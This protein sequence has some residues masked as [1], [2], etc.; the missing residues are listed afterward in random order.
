MDFTMQSLNALFNR[1]KGIGFFERLFG[2]NKVQGLLTDASAELGALQQSNMENGKQLSLKEISLSEL[3]KDVDLLKISE[4]TLQLKV[5]Q[6]AAE[7][8][9]LREAG[10]KVKQMHA[11]EL[12]S[13]RQKELTIL[14]LTNDRNNIQEKYNQIAKD[15]NEVKV[16]LASL[17][18]NEEF[19][20]TEHNDAVSSL[21]A[22][23]QKI[24]NDREKELEK[25]QE[26]E[27]DRISNLKTTWSEHQTLA[28][29]FIKA[30]CGKHTIEFVD[31]VPFKGTPDNT[32]KVA[33]EYIVFDAKSPG[34]EDLNNFPAYIKREAE[35]A[36]KYASQD[37]VRREIFFV[38]PSNTLE[39]V[40]QFVYP[41]AEYT[42]Y[43]ISLDALEPVILSLKRIE[44]YEFAEELTPEERSN[45]C[46]VLGKF[47]H[48]T[49]RRIQVD[50]FFAK[51]AIELAY[52]A[53]ATLPDFI[54]EEVINFERADKL[55]PP[56]E[57]RTKQIPVKDLEKDINKL[58]QEAKG[59]GINIDSEPLADKI[60]E[61]PLYDN[62]VNE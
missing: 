55:N 9:T 50:S 43:L 62:E 11:A 58:E 19:R 36:K 33:G 10:G 29:Q 1:L 30:I 40:K 16:K 46:R 41:M 4:S 12:A 13:N 2:W 60:N 26:K 27:Q 56:L 17:E 39:V 14:D 61:L 42:V 52:N 49:K 5:N 54:L 28:Q 51:Q 25:L 18:K 34:G 7:I 47:A 32:I 38:I 57:K 3:R 37:E 53:E 22:I 45:I 21:K 15:L 59:R 35:A 20:K 48:L 24:E 31:K 8:D 44:E 23:Q 6:Q